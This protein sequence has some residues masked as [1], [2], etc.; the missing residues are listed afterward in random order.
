MRI[1]VGVLLNQ[2]RGDRVHL[3][4]RLRPRDSRFH[5]RDRCQKM[6]NLF[7]VVEPFRKYEGRP[8]SYAFWK[9]RFAS[10]DG[11]VG[12]TL[13][14]NGHSQ[15]V[16]GVAPEK[17]DWFIK[18][19]SLTT[20]KPQDNDVVLTFWFIFR[21]KRAADDGIDSQHRK[22]IRGYKLHD[23]LLRLTAAGEIVPLVGDC[24]HA[25]ERIILA[26][27]IEKIRRRH[28]IVVVGLLVV[29]LPD[30]HQVL[31]ILI[32]KGLQERRIDDGK[33]GGVRSDA[34]REREDSHRCKAG[35][36]SQHTC[37]E[38]QILCGSL[39]PADDVH[40]ARVL[41]MQAGI[42]ESAL[43]LV[44]RF[45]GIHAGSDVFFRA[46]LHVRSKFFL[47]LAVQFVS[48]K[49]AAQA[50]SQRHSRSLSHTNCKTCATACVSC[51]QF[52]SSCASCFLPLAVSW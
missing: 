11:I 43:S 35:A 33:D 32:R 38:T 10:D 14:L 16:I 30:N 28:R 37:S 48:V 4:L 5:A 24:R 23:H 40:R 1:V 52:F 2:A 15:T 7:P 36:A 45:F 26:L 13:D 27:P 9:E 47:Q 20:A 34:K 21:G 44:P 8:E 49:Q 50:R 29:L 25:R 22:E 51:A 17:F 31:G 19:G 3:R 41:L 12:K 39:Q 6:P 18:Q 42:A 46:H